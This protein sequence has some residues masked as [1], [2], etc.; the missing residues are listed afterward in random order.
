[1]K[2]HM[3]P[4]QAFDDGVDCKVWF[5]HGVADV[6][7]DVSWSLSK[8]DPSTCHIVEKEGT[9]ATK[10]SLR[11]SAIE[12][13]ISQWLKQPD[14]VVYR[15]LPLLRPIP[16]IEYFVGTFRSKISGHGHSFVRNPNRTR[17]ECLVCGH[18]NPISG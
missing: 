14:N 15:P 13:H 3:K 11:L 16:Q 5:L 7:A 6:L 17:L 4:Q 2:S 18:L 10:I 1:M 9:L 8:W 12:T